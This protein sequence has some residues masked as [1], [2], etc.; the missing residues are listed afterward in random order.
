M[1]P[2]D[3]PFPALLSS[4]ACRPSDV[5]AVTNLIIFQATCRF[6]VLRHN[7]ALFVIFVIFFAVCFAFGFSVCAF[8]AKA[9]RVTPISSF[10]LLTPRL[11]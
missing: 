1:L 11:I 2:F 10:N 5:S 7:S 4:K 9:R 3:A 8:L 6:C